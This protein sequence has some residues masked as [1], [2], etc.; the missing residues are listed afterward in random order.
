[1]VQIKGTAVLDTIRLVK[2]RTGD[3]GFNRIVALLDEEPRKMF[4]NEVFSST[5]YPLDAFTHF[6]EVQIRESASGNVEVLVKGS[7][8]VVERQLRGIYKVFVKLGSPEF[9]LKRIAA[10]H[11]TYFKGVEIKVEMMGP[12][13]ATIRYTGYEQRHRIIGYAIIGFFRKALEISG[14]RNVQAGFATPIEA[15][16]DYAE[17]AISWT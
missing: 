10:V 16:K 9:V 7:E 17:L 15:G 12:G 11:A 2:Q 14:A 6:L 5:W 8:E 4:Q 13:N 3:D 1:M